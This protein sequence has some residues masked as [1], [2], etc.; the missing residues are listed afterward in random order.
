[1]F[2]EFELVEWIESQATPDPRVCLAAGDD[3]AILQAEGGLLLAGVDQVVDGM[4]FDSTVHSPAQI[5]RKVMNRNLSDCAAMGCLPTAALAAVVFP[6]QASL[7]DAKELYRGMQQAGQLHGCVIVGGDTVRW[8]GKLALSLTILGRSAGV[9][10]IRRS[11]AKVGD[12]I[13]VTGAL[14]GSILGRHMDFAPR[15][16]LGR[17]LA[18]QKVPS[19]MIDLSDGLSR[20]L[21][22]ICRAS[23]V[24]ALLDAGQIPI[25]PDVHRLPPGPR[26]PLEHALHDGEDYELLLTSSRVAVPEGICIGTIVAGHDVWIGRDGRRELLPALGWEH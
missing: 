5:G 12:R 14:G 22:Q 8:G 24:G 4:H 9:E 19:A 15:V 6:L 16:E 2:R 13:Y 23:G 3:L 7:D 20:D 25:H 26:T 10:P 21:R 11:G 1:M 17:R 18:E